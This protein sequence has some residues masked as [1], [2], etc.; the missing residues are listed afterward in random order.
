M[1]LKI[2]TESES[3]SE[4]DESVRISRIGSETRIFSKNLILYSE[5]K[6]KNYIEFFVDNIKIKL[7]IT[8]INTQ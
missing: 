1:V 6:K 3:E 8:I 4:S 5:N 2:R 7:E